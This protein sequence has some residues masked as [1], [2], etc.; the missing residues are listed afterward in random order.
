MNSSTAVGEARPPALR[1]RL[2]L[3]VTGAVQ[4]VGF[5]P[6]VYRLAR[7]LGLA[8]WV[9]NN[10]AGV[11]IE[12]EGDSETAAAFA[13]RLQREAPPLARIDSI[14]RREVAPTGEAIFDIRSSESA[15]AA[16]PRTLILPDIATCPECLAD[17]LRP[18]DRRY[19]YPFT[20]CTNCGPRFSII[21]ALPYDRART[22]LR[23]F[24]LC[25]DCAAEYA[26]PADR[27]F[28]AQ[29]TA[30]PTCGP[31]TT[32]M[33]RNEAGLWQE[34]RIGDEAV[35]E[36]GAAL[37]AG[38]IVALKGLGGFQLLVDATNSQ[39]V[40]ALR[41][42]KARPH[43]PFALLAQDIAAVETISHVDAEER[44]LLSSPAAPIV[45][46]QR[47][48]AARIAAEVA[49]G[50]P[51]LGIMLPTTPLHH[52]LARAVGRPLVATSG[53]L[54]DE[55]IC[56]HNE[57]AVERLGAIA[58]LFL[59]HNRPI[60]RPVDDSVAHVLAG[61]PRLVRRARGFAPLPVRMAH[62]VSQLL[63]AGAHLK[64]ALAVSFGHEA[65][66]SQHIGDLSS[67]QALAAYERAAADLLTLFR[68]EP[69]A[70]AHD[71]HPD[72]L[73]T[74]W[75][76]KW[77]QARGLPLVTVQHHH[78]HLA[79]C[80]ADNGATTD[81]LG[82]TWDGSGLG[83]DGTLWGGEFLLGD[84]R[85]VQRVASL[86]PFPLPGGDAA[87]REP[88]RS[89]LALLYAME[90]EAALERTDLP[91]LQAFSASE[92]A[93]LARMM[94]QGIASPRSSSAGRLFDGLA[95]LMG[96]RQQATF[97]GQAAMDLES[98]AD[99]CEQGAYPVAL[100]AGSPRLLD[101]EPLTRALLEEQAR[102]V[103]VSVM[104][105]RIWRGM[106]Q[107]IVQV[108]EQVGHATVALSG[109]CFQNRLLSEWSRAALSRAGFEVLLHR[110]TP[111]N[112]G[113]IA[114][115]QI[116]VTAAQLQPQE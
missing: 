83:T 2:R 96:L 71:L 46:L 37:L 44:A 100:L 36:A 47:R 113:C 34:I 4:G 57:E 79:A 89:A 92:R 63:A 8:G 28:H 90:G 55:P 111:P 17:I 87:A 69:V 97:E 24:R 72:Y 27:R 39:A 32:L 105:A 53:N 6:H 101:W 58:D 10:G 62:P 74:Q 41:Q 104:A 106:A 88:R 64:N 18:D 48:A 115:G 5:R 54:S 76:Q 68:V 26:N 43:K 98:A 22:T 15:P 31:H 84:A 103:A 7:A 25:P 73:S 38:K 110:Q 12:V 9:L 51:R 102:G 116:A 65:V 40:G 33:E 56:I 112:D 67:A 77:A 49:P 99:P 80:L 21:H 66:L 19:H 23:D 81:A 3:E 50:C 114:L 107:A 1:C 35:I 94:A 108:A 93:L 61:E 42:R 45:L 85:A 109:G 14:R 20:N 13:E 29:P 95:A 70:V 91:P 30:C 75:A 52:L 82:V 86:R 78:A 11:V 16:L 60:A 59:L